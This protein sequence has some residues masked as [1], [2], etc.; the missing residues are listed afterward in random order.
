MHEIIFPIL[1]QLW[2]AL[3]TLFLFSFGLALL[4]ALGFL[5][6]SITSGWFYR[7]LLDTLFYRSHRTYAELRST[8]FWFVAGTLVVSA[9]A[10][11]I[12]GSLWHNVKVN[13]SNDF[14]VLLAILAIGWVIVAAYMV[15]RATAQ[16]ISLGVSLTKGETASQLCSSD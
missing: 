2:Q 4:L 14:A 9:E 13:T 10:A 11:V 15:L 7:P 3:W 12:F 1:G 8:S 16:L 6:W 5:F